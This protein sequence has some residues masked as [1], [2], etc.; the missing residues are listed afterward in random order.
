[1]AASLAGAAGGPA[2]NPGARAQTGSPRLTGCGVVLVAVS[3][4]APAPTA[5]PMTTPIGPP[6]RPM[7]AP[8]PAP[9]AIPPEV[10]P[11]W[12]LPQPVSR[13]SEAMAKT[14]GW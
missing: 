7:A 9:V 4:P 10:R 1:M 2:G 5:A 3:A 12:L 8:V 6:M 11:G 13:P 14:A